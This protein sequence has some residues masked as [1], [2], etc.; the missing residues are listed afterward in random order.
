MADWSVVFAETLEEYLVLYM[1]ARGDLDERAAVLKHCR[2]AITQSPKV[3][4]DSIQLPTPLH[5][6][7]RKEFL[8]YLAED[9]QAEEEAAMKAIE[10]Q[11]NKKLT[12]DEHAST[13]KP[14]KAGDYHKLWDPFCTAQ[15]IFKEEANQ[16]DEQSRDKSDKK[17]FGAHTKALREWWNTLDVERKEEASR[18]AGSWNAQGAP[19]EKQA[20]KKNLRNDTTEF[21]DTLR[22]SMG[23]HAVVLLAY[24]SGDDMK[25]TIIEANPPMGRNKPFS[26]FSDG[27]KKWA[28]D[29]G[30]YLAEYVFD[31][32][33]S[34]SEDEDGDN[35][36]TPVVKV[37]VNGNL[38]LPQ[39]KSH[40]LKAGQDVVCEIFRKAYIKITTRAKVAVPWLLLSKTPTEYI[41]PAC[42]PPG[43]CITDPS[44][45]TK[46]AIAALWSHWQQR[47]KQNLPILSFIKARR[48]DLPGRQAP[49]EFHP[50]LK[51]D[52][53]EIDPAKT[54]EEEDVEN[55][56]TK[57]AVEDIDINRMEASG[58]DG[59]PADDPSV[60]DL[61]GKRK[62]TSPI[63]DTSSGPSAKRPRR[64]LD[65]Q[66]MVPEDTSPAANQLVRGT[67]LGSL[68]TDPADLELFSAL[69]ALPRLPSGWPKSRA[70][71]PRWASWRWAKKYLPAEVHANSD[72]FHVALGMLRRTKFTDAGGGTPVVLGLGLLLQECWRAVEVEP[73]AP[74]FPDFLVNSSLGHKRAEDV[75]SIIR[76]IIGDLPSPNVQVTE[77]GANHEADLGS[78]EDAK[79]K[80][81]GV[82]VVKEGEDGG[83]KEKE[84]PEAE[85]SKAEEKQGKKIIPKKKKGKKTIAPPDSPELKSKR[86]RKPSKR[87]LG[88]T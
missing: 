16:I 65:D 26:M 34:E 55:N 33:K 69:H 9:D 40:C 52:Y 53:V 27:L 57:A 44:K 60:E 32:E 71:L 88:E 76:Q 12:P 70:N 80:D 30:E 41:D 48:E 85:S 29:G 18:V 11:R 5:L 79:G 2:D 15:W 31:E 47:E 42:I 6:A 54:T 7:I 38:L 83:G 74:G 20:A 39:A 68:S 46:I 72:V 36:T 37:D 82:E 25:T 61:A 73:N 78:I 24:K 75:V 14:T 50:A 28:K 59:A 81:G 4:K 1:D 77:D 35:D 64:S 13:A 10:D 19:P 17:N 63:P 43:F 22:Q 87:V 62:A 3:E 23:V 66:P 21:V 84:G 67:F 58:K 8:S 86:Q 49:L 45:F 56:P 51:R